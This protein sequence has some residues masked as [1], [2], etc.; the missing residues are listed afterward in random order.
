VLFYSLFYFLS[1]LAEQ[2]QEQAKVFQK[3]AFDKAQTRAGRGL[4]T[5]KEKLE[6]IYQGKKQQSAKCE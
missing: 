5:K 6:R 2:K 4:D 3:T 1:W